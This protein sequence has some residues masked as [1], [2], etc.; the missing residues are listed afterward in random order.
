MA[1]ENAYMSDTECGQIADRY[2][3][4][5]ELNSID[6]LEHMSPQQQWFIGMIKKMKTR[7]DYDKTNNSTRDTRVF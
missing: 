1:Q 6:Y 3:W 4:K 5:N 7:I 2:L